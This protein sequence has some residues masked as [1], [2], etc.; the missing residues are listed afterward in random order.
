MNDVGMANMSHRRKANQSPFCPLSLVIEQ[1]VKGTE[2]EVYVS[3]FNFMQ[4]FPKFI[5]LD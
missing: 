5:C 1:V 4:Y 2:R 3:S